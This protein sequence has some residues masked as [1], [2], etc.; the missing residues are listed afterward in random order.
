MNVA[1]Q[2]IAWR[3]VPVRSRTGQPASQPIDGAGASLVDR[4]LQH[5]ANLTQPL[6]VIAGEEEGDGIHERVAGA[7]GTFHIHPHMLPP[8]E[9]QLRNPHHDTGNQQRAE[10]RD[11][12]RIDAH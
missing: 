4:L 12:K 3:V 1:R 7:P 11:D 8:A 2:G 5:D 6:R 10:K 9:R